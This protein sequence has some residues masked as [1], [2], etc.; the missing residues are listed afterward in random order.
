MARSERILVTGA[1][2]YIGGRLVPRLLQEEYRVRVLVRSRVRVLS[3]P[4]SD[5]VEILTGDIFDPQTLAKVLAGVDSAY[6][7]IHSMSRGS[8]FHN[9][10]LE[11]A[12]AFGQEAQKAGVNRIIY[13]G[14]LGDPEGNLSQHLR[15][16]QET[17]QALREGGVPV[18]E[19][20]AAV[21]VGSGSISFEMIR[22]LVERLPVMIC[23]RWIYSRIQPIAVQDVLEYLVGALDTPAS[24]GLTIEIGG[25]N[26]TTYKGLMLGYAEKRGLRRLLLAVPVL[27][28]R[29]SSYWVHW[30]TPI[31]SDITVALVE[32]LRNDVIVTDDLARTIFPH[33][34]PQ[35]YASAIDI[36]IN[37]LDE[38]RI[39]TSWSDAV[40]TTPEQDNPVR[41]ETRQGM[42]IERRRR[43]VAASAQAVYRVC[44]GIGAA[45][46]WYFANWTWR[47]RGMVDRLLGGAGL[48]RGRRH[49]DNLRIGD[50][51]DFWRV[52]DLKAD[53]LVR[54]RAEMKL[55]GRAWLQF[56]MREA[57]DGTTHLEQTAAFIPKGLT[58]LAYWYGLYPVHAWIF[59]G[60]ARAIA[61]RAEHRMTSREPDAANH[62]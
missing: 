46:G 17:G 48:R 41:L 45:R 27:T 28:P 9:L 2:G 57:Q 40:G 49:P 50:A 15:S 23:P 30:L 52:E 18:T 20:R 25:K 29:L 51:L 56:E 53:R 11:A 54:L 38:G 34:E 47:L 39:D 14:G 16:R 26:T 24:R 36:V 44:T 19:F 7:L 32:G 22:Y 37:D 35:D 33:I 4:W 1:T 31:P 21:I 3:R 43:R 6:Y 58:G 12:R 8:N 61:S 10:D 13:L 62:R 5:Q 59:G 60:L 42:I 55:P